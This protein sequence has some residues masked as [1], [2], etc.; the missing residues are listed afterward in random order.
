MVADALLSDKLDL[1]TCFPEAFCQQL[2][3]FFVGYYLIS[4]AVHMKYRYAGLRNGFTG[5][6]WDALI[7]QYR[8]LIEVMGFEA[9]GPCLF[10]TG[11]LI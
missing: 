1:P 3:V 4:I 11:P 6:K 10:I 2:S 8:L 9:G 5:G 7:A